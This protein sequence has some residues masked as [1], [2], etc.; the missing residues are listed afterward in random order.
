MAKEPVADISALIC[1]C[2]ISFHT[3]TRPDGRLVA[4]WDE[5]PPGLMQMCFGR[6]PR[7]GL[8]Y[9]TEFSAEET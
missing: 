1:N 9:H 4:V 8:P 2:S 3:E 6:C 5:Q 7:C